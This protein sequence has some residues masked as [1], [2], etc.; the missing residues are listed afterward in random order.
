MKIADITKIIEGTLF[1]SGEG[2]DKD[3]FK[4]IYDLSDKELNKCLDALKEKYNED[5]GINIITFKNKIQL[6]SNPKY[7]DNIA[8]ILNPIRERSLTK[9]ALETVAI[10]A[11]KQPITRT[12]I[13]QIRGVNCDYAVQ[14][15]QSNNLIE[16]V[17]RKDAVGKPLLFGTTEDFLKRF[18]LNSLDELPNHKEL[19]DRIRVIH[20][21][22]DSLY[23]EF[24]IPE[25]GSENNAEGVEGENGNQESTANIVA[26]A[27]SEPAMEI[28][29]NDPSVTESVK[30]DDEPQ[31]VGED[32]EVKVINPAPKKRRRNPLLEPNGEVNVVACANDESKTINSEDDK[33]GGEKSAAL[34]ETTQ[35]L[36]NEIANQEGAQ[37]GES[38]A[39]LSWQERLKMRM[40]ENN[41][42]EE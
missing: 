42:P 13:E 3:E 8:E 38:G 11:Y 2:V 30:V 31:Y 32:Q 40:A 15:L 17:G 27:I 23:R 39:K 16:V 29:E 28:D 10:V 36:P 4:R 26:D 21:E 18:E 20:S 35:S 7:A 19:L 22:G 41:N 1:V 9:A 6:C 33:H 14:L 34:P 25:E 37:N 12:E 5:S 24:T